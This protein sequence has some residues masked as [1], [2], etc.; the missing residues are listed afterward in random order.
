MSI[1]FKTIQ[2]GQPGVAGGGEKKH[3][4]GPVMS[5]EPPV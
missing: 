1:K 3:Y 2:K 5:G 4:A